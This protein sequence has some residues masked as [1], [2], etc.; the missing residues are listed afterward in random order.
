MGF[1]PGRSTED[2]LFVLEKVIERCIDKHVPLFFASLDLRKAF[3][4][5]EWNYL[6]EA[7]AQQGV[8]VEYRSLLAA[9]Y[10]G[11]ASSR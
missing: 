9:L 3:D 4:R 1:L 7:L 10:A 5:I 11:R 8:P 2:A 6:F